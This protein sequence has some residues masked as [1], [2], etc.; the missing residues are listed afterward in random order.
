[1]VRDEAVT[2]TG[3][4]VPKHHGD[5]SPLQSLVQGGNLSFEAFRG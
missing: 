1:M 4:G 2:A 3:I 5:G